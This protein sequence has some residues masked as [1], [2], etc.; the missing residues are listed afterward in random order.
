M[1]MASRDGGRALSP[2]RPLPPQGPSPTT[3]G[4]YPTSQKLCPCS[5]DNNFS[6]APV[7]IIYFLSLSFRLMRLGKWTRQM[8]KEGEILCNTIVCITKL[9]LSARP[10]DFLELVQQR[11]G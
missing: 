5:L 3:K 10:G 9:V 11:W 2:L 8:G 7:F 1:D 4:R 6:P